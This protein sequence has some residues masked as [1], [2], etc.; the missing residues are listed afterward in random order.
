MMKDNKIEEIQTKLSIYKNVDIEKYRSNALDL[1]IA[2]NSV[3]QL[4]LEY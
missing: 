2:S 3:K 1:K 4:E